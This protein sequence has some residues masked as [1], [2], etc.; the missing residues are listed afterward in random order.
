M[1]C[2]SELFHRPTTLRE[3]KYFLISLMH[4][5]FFNFIVWPLLPLTCCV[6]RRFVTGRTGWTCV[7]CTGTTSQGVEKLALVRLKCSKVVTVCVRGHHST[8]S[9]VHVVNTVLT[10]PTVLISTVI[11]VSFRNRW[12]HRPHILNPC[13]VFIKGY[14]SP[15]RKL[16]LRL[17]S[18]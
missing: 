15:F 13:P 14:G 9:H 18:G 3:K 6:S 11:K 4:P 7:A 10:S 17:G 1:H 8:S 5:G 2:W 12:K 16:G